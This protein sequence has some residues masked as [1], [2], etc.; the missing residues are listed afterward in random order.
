MKLAY[1]IDEAVNASSIK[2][3]K[4]YE[5]IRG[6]KLISKKAHGRMLILADDLK[7]FLDTLP[8]FVPAGCLHDDA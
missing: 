2:C 4:L 1:P 6:K 8:D 7:L 3:S 5:H